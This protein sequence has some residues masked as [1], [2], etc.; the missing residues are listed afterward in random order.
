DD[1]SAGDDQNALRPGEVLASMVFDENVQVAFAALSALVEMDPETAVDKLIAILRSTSQEDARLTTDDTGAESSSTAGAVETIS[2]TGED[3]SPEIQKMLAGHNAT[4]STLASILAT[5]G[6]QDKIKPDD[7]QRQLDHE[8][9]QQVSP[10]DA[11]RVLAA[12]LLGGLANPGG[13]AVEVLIDL[14]TNAGIELRKEAIGALGRIGDPKALPNLLSVLDAPQVELRQATVEAL[15]SFKDCSGFE[16]RLAQMLDDSDPMIRQRSLQILGESGS[17]LA[18]EQLL[19]MLDDGDL[20]VCRAAL[21]IINQETG[22]N[23]I[24]DR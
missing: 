4:T 24:I 19:N 10:H 7:L 3:V 13:Q 21:R 5:P 1:L 15:G 20:E 12:R 23:K 9:G 2:N 17:E 22:N 6:A 16:Q 11:I 18:Q 8:I 14:T